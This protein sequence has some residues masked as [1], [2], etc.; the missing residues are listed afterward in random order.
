M[1][2][3]DTCCLERSLLCFQPAEG[4]VMCYEVK[5]SLCVGWCPLSESVS[6]SASVLYLRPDSGFTS[7]STDCGR[8]ERTYRVLQCEKE[9]LYWKY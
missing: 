8:P 7:A 1:L 2:N 3:R 5:S 6:L 4:Q 9:T